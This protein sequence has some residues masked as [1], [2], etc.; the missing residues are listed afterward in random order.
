MRL[1]KINYHW[2]KYNLNVVWD[3]YTDK[4]TRIHIVKEHTKPQIL[5]NAIVFSEDDMSMIE[6][7]IDSLD[8]SE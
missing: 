1:T 6:E 7:I 3:G 8:N 4:G 5:A 2:K